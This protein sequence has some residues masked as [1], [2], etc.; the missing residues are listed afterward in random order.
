MSMY[1]PLTVTELRCVTQHLQK[2]FASWSSETGAGESWHVTPQYHTQRF[3]SVFSQRNPI[4]G[5]SR[6]SQAKTRSW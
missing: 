5:I 1:N 3:T 2:T 6:Q 4:L